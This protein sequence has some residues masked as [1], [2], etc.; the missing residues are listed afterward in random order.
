MKRSKTWE[1]HKPRVD[2]LYLV[3]VRAT[4]S[5]SLERREWIWSIDRINGLGHTSELARGRT[6]TRRECKTIATNVA[7]FYDVVERV[8]N[9]KRCDQGVPT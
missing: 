8:A 5:P 2:R 3:R 1:R 9:G 4:I 7:A 6:S